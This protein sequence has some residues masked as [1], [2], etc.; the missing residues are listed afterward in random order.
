VV[1]DL[2]GYQAYYS[3]KL[4]NLLPQIYRA[5]DATAP[6]DPTTPNPPSGPLQEIVN[7]IGAQAATLRRS[8]DRMWEDQS[9]ESCDDWVIP[10]IAAQL[11]TNLV[12]SLDPR[13]QRLAIFNT[14]SVRQRRGT[15][16]ALEQIAAETTGWD[17]RVVELYHRLS[18]ARH[19]LDPPFGWPIEKAVHGPEG[20]R[21][22]S[23]AV[24][25]GLIGANTGTPAGGYADLRNVFGVSRAGTAFDELA[26]TAD[27]RQG[28]GRTGWYNIP[29]VGVFLWRLQSVPVLGVTPVPVFGG[30]HHY[31]FDPT[32]RDVPLF[33]VSA[34]AFG[35]A[36]TPR[37]EYQLPGPID[38]RLLQTALPKLYAATDPTGKSLLPNAIGLYSGPPGVASLVPLAQ[39]SADPHDATRYVIDAVRGRVAPPHGSHPGPALQVGYCYGFASSIGAGGYERRVPGQTPAAA[40]P[41][42]P[43]VTGGGRGIVA[44]SSGTVQIGDSLTYDHAPDFTVNGS[45]I[46]RASDQQRPLVRPAPASHG[47]AHWTFTGGLGSTLLLDGLFV[48]GGNVVLA[49]N[50]ETVTLSTCTLDPGAW[51]GRAPRHAADGRPLSPVHLSITGTV[52]NLVIDRCILGPIV[53]AAAGIAEQVTITNSILQVVSPHDAIE[54]ETGE[55]SISGCTVLG[56]GSFRELAACNSL[57]CDVVTVADDQQGCVRF[58]AWTHGSRLPR[59]YESVE[60]EPGRDLFASTDFGQPHYAQLLPTVGPDIGAGAEDGSEMGAFSQDK[61]PI[62]QRSLLIMLQESLPIGLNPV[63]VYVT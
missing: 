41:V 44:A 38:Q 3:A 36:W 37:D 12:S 59:Q 53:V 63:L 34:Q 39:V 45:L 20:T 5:Y 4:W 14:I 31:T 19:G 16:P 35:S 21:Q 24:A 60:L 15:I 6:F 51:H 22:P 40:T 46:V 8:I 11:S 23:L 43:T 48:S 54:I 13:A 52:R 62:K 28:Q 49:G 9:I 55:T 18:R 17:V 1:D 61:N 32:G 50:F 56:K 30:A 42:M 27:V 57:F 47:P 2:D 29:Q 58:S 26:Y 25:A 10:Y 33:A 7:R